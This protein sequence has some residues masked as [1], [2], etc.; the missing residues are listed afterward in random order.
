MSSKKTSKAVAN[1]MG[2]IFL[3][4]FLAFILDWA[5]FGL[6]GIKP[7]FYCMTV[8]WAAESGIGASIS[9]IMIFFALFA[10]ISGSRDTAAILCFGGFA[11]PMIP[12]LI[13]AYVGIAC[14]IEPALPLPPPSP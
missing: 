5:M 1:I 2:I 13:V 4:L 7:F 10:F 9:L 14:I 11:I 8:V 6:F 12:K 3:L